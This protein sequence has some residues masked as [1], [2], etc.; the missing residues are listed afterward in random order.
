MALD[1]SVP[2]LSPTTGIFSMAPRGSHFQ[3]PT[4]RQTSA[5][6]YRHQ[7]PR[8]TARPCSYSEP[9][10]PAHLPTCNDRR[11][12]NSQ[13]SYIL[14]L[15]G[16]REKL[17]VSECYHMRLI[18]RPAGYAEQQQYVRQIMRNRTTVNPVRARRG[19][20]CTFSGRFIGIIVEKTRLFFIG[21][22]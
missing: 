10:H 3:C 1:N 16:G 7:S 19:V 18:R 13:Y 20:F 17:Q 22:P 6:V 11:I 2:S 5:A 14:Q 21:I 8:S 9:P 4:Q 15:N 12:A